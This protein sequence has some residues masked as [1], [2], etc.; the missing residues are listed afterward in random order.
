MVKSMTCKICGRETWKD[1]EGCEY[2]VDGYVDQESNLKSKV[3]TKDM[4]GLKIHKMSCAYS[5]E[6][7]EYTVHVTLKEISSEGLELF[8]L[9]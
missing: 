1:C 4:V 3:I 2:C 9:I 7:D 6:S 5:R 8:G